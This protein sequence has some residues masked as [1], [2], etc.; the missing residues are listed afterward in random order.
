MCRRA[1][2]I[3]RLCVPFI[4]S[5]SGSPLHVTFVYWYFADTWKRNYNVCVSG[6]HCDLGSILNGRVRG[7]SLLW[8]AFSTGVCSAQSAARRS[9]KTAAST[10]VESSRHPAADPRIPVA[11]QTTT[12]PIGYAYSVRSNCECFIFGQKKNRQSYTL[13]SFRYKKEQWRIRSDR[14][15]FDVRWYR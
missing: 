6:E 7:A 13:I 9:V 15:L 4:H 5:T 12:P 1:S 14:P 2:K 10:I 11:V 8:A 3:V